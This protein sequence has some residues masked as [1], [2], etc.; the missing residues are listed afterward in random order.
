[1]LLDPFIEKLN[2][3]ALPVE[4]RDSERI[5]L[6]VVGN[7]PVNKIGSIVFICHHSDGFGVMFSRFVAC[8]PNHFLTD[9]PCMIINGGRAFNDIL[10]IVFCP[11]DKKCS[12]LVDKIEHPKKSK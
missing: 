2:L 5:K 11:G 10:H 6:S 4:F 1:M 9:N 3:P 12:L 8:K 7:E